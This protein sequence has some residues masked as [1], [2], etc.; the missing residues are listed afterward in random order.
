M[1]FNPPPGWPV[2]RGWN[3]PPEWSPDPAW[4]PAPP[5]WRFWIDAEPRVPT[6]QPPHAWPG[7]L[8]TSRETTRN[9]RVVALAAIALVVIAAAVGVGV[10]V[11]GSGDAT[12]TDGVRA[13]D[14]VTN[15]P[16]E[17]SATPSSE[18]SEAS[19]SPAAEQCTAGAT[20]AIG[21]TELMYEDRGEYNRSDAVELEV[22]CGGDQ[23]TVTMT[24][25]Q[26]VDMSVAGF[27]A[28]VDRDPDA[29]M[30]GGHSCD[31]DNT[32]DISISVDGSASGSTWS[33][34]DTTSCQSPY[35][36]LA[37]GSSSTTG[38]SLAATVPFADVGITS[39]DSITLYAF[40]STYLPPNLLD[41]GQDY[42]PD[43]QPL[44]VSIG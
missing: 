23:L 18:Q 8:D 28:L 7:P 31:G 4:P 33:V 30:Q 15:I 40:S 9:L 5:G 6:T 19:T 41:P 42:I 39:G 44:R 36:V 32:D 22:R 27:A 20:D 2:P 13:D 1:I 10:L 37:S 38:L 24:F 21:D 3:P 12:R 11:G 14:G 29:G 26:G 17:R 35:P 16:V 43:G 25:A 34:L